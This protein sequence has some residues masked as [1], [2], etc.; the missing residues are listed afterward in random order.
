MVVSIARKAEPERIVETPSFATGRLTRSVAPA[1][2]GIAL[3]RSYQGRM[4]T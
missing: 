3:D 4:L 1:V 2:S